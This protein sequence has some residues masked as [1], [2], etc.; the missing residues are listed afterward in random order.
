MS[1][2]MNWDIDEFRINV[3]CSFGY[4][5]DESRYLEKLSRSM[6]NECN[7]NGWSLTKYGNY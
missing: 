3:L 4:Y 6:S 7:R 1:R 2:G 5:M